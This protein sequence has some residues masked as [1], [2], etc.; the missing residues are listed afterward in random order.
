[1]GAALLSEQLYIESSVDLNQ[2]IIRMNQVIDGLEN[3]VLT[4]ALAGEHIDEYM[5]NDGQTIIRTKYRSVATI[6]K[7]ID[8]MEMIKQR[9]VNRL[10]GRVINLK[11]SQAIRYYNGRNFY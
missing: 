6:S 4:A 9:Y 10:N 3:A 7:A 11:D 1:M 2:K 8:A 5:L